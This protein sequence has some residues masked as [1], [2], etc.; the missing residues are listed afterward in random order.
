MKRL[1]C[2]L[3]AILFV[4]GCAL[5]CSAEDSDYSETGKNI[6][7]IGDWIYEKINNGTQWEMDEYIG[8]GGE[9]IVPWRTADIMV[10]SL[11]DHCFANNTSVTSVITTSPPWSIGDYCFID[12]TAL[13][14][15]QLNLMM[16]HIGIGAFSGTIRLKNINLEDS[17]VTKIEPYTFLNSGIEHIELPE[18]CT[19]IDNYAFGQCYQLTKI[20]IPRSVETIHEDA[21]RDSDNLTIYCYEDSAAH[22]FAVA[23]EIPFVLIDDHPTTETFILGD[24]D[25]SGNIDIVDATFIQRYDINATVPIEY[26]TLKHGDVDD[27]GSLTATDSTFIMRHIIR[28]QVPYQIGE[29]VTVP[30]D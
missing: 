25:G 26:S 12:C 2:L 15:I 30:L 28:M 13:E 23:N 1:L 4:V 11:G 16:D 29:E 22:Q 10:V 6:V 5:S 8:A 7:V 21:F 27:D 9:V 3:L 17:I 19:E 24:S 20:V 14:T 18:T